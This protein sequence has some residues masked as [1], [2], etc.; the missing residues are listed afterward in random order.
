MQIVLSDD[1]KIALVNGQ[2]LKVGGP[3]T[4]TNDDKKWVKGIIIEFLLINS[5]SVWCYAKEITENKACWFSLRLWA[6][7]QEIKETKTEIISDDFF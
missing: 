3:V 1:K 6:E 7:R 5:N 2:E 4:F